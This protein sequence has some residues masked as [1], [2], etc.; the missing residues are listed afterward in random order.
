MFWQ[1]LKFTEGW[2]GAPANF[3]VSKKAQKRPKKDPKKGPKRPKICIKKLV[4]CEYI[5][6][7]EYS[8]SY[9]SVRCYVWDK[10]DY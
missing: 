9:T 8:H 2:G 1:N 6:M 5:F 4:K 3:G 10:F 7:D